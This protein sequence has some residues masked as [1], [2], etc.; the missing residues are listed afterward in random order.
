MLDGPQ[1]HTHLSQVYTWLAQTLFYQL[2]VE[3]CKLILDVLSYILWQTQFQPSVLIILSYSPYHR[4]GGILGASA[5]LGYAGTLRFIVAFLGEFCVSI[6][7]DN[8]K[9]SRLEAYVLATK[10]FL[11]DLVAN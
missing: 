2:F 9:I 5:I 11:M 7:E 3:Q 1:L 4:Y 10:K 8:P 6:L